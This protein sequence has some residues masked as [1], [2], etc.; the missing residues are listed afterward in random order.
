MAVLVAPT[1]AAVTTP[2][3]LVPV[4]V[5]TAVLLLVHVPPGVVEFNVVL[6]PAH[7]FIDPVMVAGLAFTVTPSVCLQPPAMV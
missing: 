1:N 7:T 2:V 6:N 3:P 5:A 4:T